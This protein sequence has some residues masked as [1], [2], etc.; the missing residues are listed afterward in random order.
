MKFREHAITR[1]IRE[2]DR[3]LYAKSTHG[4]VDIMRKNAS[5][6]SYDIDGERVLF[7]R[8]ADQLVM[9]LTDNWSASGEPRDWGIE[10]ILA[11]LRAMD[12]WSRPEFFEEIEL[13][14]EKVRESEKRDLSN[15]VESFLYDFRSAFKRTFADYNM[16]TVNK[17]DRRRLKDG[18]RQS[19]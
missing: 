7:L 10:P 5:Y 11:R 15:N 3:D 6:E 1:S 19:R 17:F 8:P 18:Y 9:S 2:Y 13:G 16:S 4:R 12:L 14:N